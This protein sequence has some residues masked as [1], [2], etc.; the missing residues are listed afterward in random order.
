MLNMHILGSIKNKYT[1]IIYIN[2]DDDNCLST[3]GFKRLDNKLFKKES[4]EARHRIKSV[5][6][7]F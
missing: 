4:I 2:T 7:A 5:T 3:I 1:Q 6:R